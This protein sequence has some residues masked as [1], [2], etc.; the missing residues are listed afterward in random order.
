MEFFKADLPFKKFFQNLVKKKNVEY[1][2]DF[3]KT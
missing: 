2:E 1:Y 3:I